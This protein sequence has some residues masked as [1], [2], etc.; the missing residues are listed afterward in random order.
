MSR[1]ILFVFYLSIAAIAKGQDGFTHIFA[2]GGIAYKEAGQASIGFDFASKYHN[3][4]ELGFTYFRTKG[5]Y[6]NY[7]ASLN[8]KPVIIRNKNSTVRFRFGG[9]LGTDLNKFVASPNLGLE[10]AQSVS[11]NIDI[12]LANNNGYYFWAN[13]SHRWR[14]AAEVG[15]RFPL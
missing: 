7:L 2:R 5:D 3:S 1:L 12:V 9:Y 11:G 4:Y 8:Y 13:K 14:I 15:V 6:Q 10:W